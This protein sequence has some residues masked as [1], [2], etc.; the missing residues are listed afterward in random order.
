[1]YPGLPNASK[2]DFSALNQPV[3]IYI[4]ISN[5]FQIIIFHVRLCFFYTLLCNV[6]FYFLLYFPKYITDMSMKRYTTEFFS[7]QEEW[8]LFYVYILQFPSVIKGCVK[9]ILK[10]LFNPQYLV[11]FLSN[12]SSLFSAYYRRVRILTVSY[13]FT[14]IIKRFRYFLSFFFRI[15]ENIYFM[16]YTQE[17][18]Y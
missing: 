12:L 1:M 4:Y 16:S 14:K 8:E 7:F 11:T 3:S 17:Y 18:I 2:V 10:N 5:R 13:F 9:D 15:P 6:S